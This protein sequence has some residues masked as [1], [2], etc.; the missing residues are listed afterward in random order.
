MDAEAMKASG[1]SSVPRLT[2]KPMLASHASRATVLVRILIGS[3]FLSEGIQKFLY[4]HELGV[5]RFAQIGIPAPSVMAPFVGVV[6]IVCG[7]LVLVGLAT[8]AAAIPLIIDMGVAIASTKV[9]ILLSKGFWAMAHEARTDWSMLLGSLFLLIVGGG[10]WSLAARLSDDR[11][12]R[13]GSDRALRTPFRRRFVS[14]P[15]HDLPGE[16][17]PCVEPVTKLHVRTAF[18][19]RASRLAGSGSE[20]HQT[21][22][23]T[24]ARSGSAQ[25]DCEFGQRISLE[26]SRPERRSAKYSHLILVSYGA[27]PASSVAA[28]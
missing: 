16:G 13:R 20:A 6:E 4:P 11:S 1:G 27:G 14:R 2:L 23:N 17:P 26:E 24:V 15:V 5:G 21:V 3:V 28:T 10:P 22:A 19:A 9:P 7:A 18:P 12:R 8:R 25:V